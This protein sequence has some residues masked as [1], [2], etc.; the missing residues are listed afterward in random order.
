MR[1]WVAQWFAL[2]NAMT[3]WCLVPLD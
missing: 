1:Y 3:A 2:T